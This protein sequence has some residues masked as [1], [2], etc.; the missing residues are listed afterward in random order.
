MK[1]KEMKGKEMKGKEMKG[2][3]MKGKEMKGKEMKGK[4]MKGKRWRYTCPTLM[5]IAY[6]YAKIKLRKSHTITCEES[7]GVYRFVVRPHGY[8]HGWELSCPFPRWLIFA[9][10]R[11]RR[12]C[13]YVYRCFRFPLKMLLRIK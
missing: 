6:F 12:F 8:N 5:F 7:D 13:L 1:G 2:K 10:M 3:E 11:M 9:E 4:E